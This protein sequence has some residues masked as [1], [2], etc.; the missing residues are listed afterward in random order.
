MAD[1]RY[2]DAKGQ[3]RQWPMYVYTIKQMKDHHGVPYVQY[4]VT[5]GNAV[6]TPARGKLLGARA[7]IQRPF[8]MHLYKNAV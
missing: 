1:E 3:L 8:V 6:C 5:D 2:V 4:A 7:E